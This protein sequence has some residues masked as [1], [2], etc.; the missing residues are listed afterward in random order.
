MVK[1][2]PL[3]WVC[4]RIPPRSSGVLPARRRAA[5]FFDGAELLVSANNLYGFAFRVSA[6]YGE[7]TYQ[8]EKILRS[9][10]AG[11]KALLVVGRTLAVFKVLNGQWVWVRPTVEMFFALGG[12]CAKLCLVARRDNK[13]LIVCEQ[14]LIALLLGIALLT[15]THQLVNRL[16]D[17]IDNL[18]R[19]TLDNTDRQ[20]VDE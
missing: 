10:H 9:Q 7:Y 2:L 12:D 14:F 1:L 19:F 5:I 11:N 4:Q 18:R 20:P 15:V 16:G 3:P 6:E 8:V 13:E 17:C